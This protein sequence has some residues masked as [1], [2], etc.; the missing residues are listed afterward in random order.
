M[1]LVDGRI[2]R[3][4]S[5][6]EDLSGELRWKANL[7]EKASAMHKGNRRTNLMS[8]IYNNLDLS[9]EDILAG[10]YDNEKDDDIE[11]DDDEEK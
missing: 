2:R 11:E 3:D 8:L 10:N 4:T 5:D 7:K 1:V 6:D 9:P